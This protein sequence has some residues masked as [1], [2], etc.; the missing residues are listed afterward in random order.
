MPELKWSPEQLIR[1]LAFVNG[2]GGVGKTSLVANLAGLYAGGGYKVL[3]VDLDPQGNVGNDLGYIGAGRSDDGKALVSA[4]STGHAIIPL[5]N[6]RPNLDVAC[7]GEQ[8]DELSDALEAGHGGGVTALAAALAQVAES[9]DLVLIDC[10]PGNKPLQ[11]LGLAAARWLVIPTKS[12]DGSR[13]GLAKVARLFTEI[14]E[15]V[16]PWIELL[17]VVLFGVGSTAT[18]VQN[19]VRADL[20]QDLDNPGIVF[21]ST[22][23]HAEAAAYDA[24]KRGQLMHEL[25]RDVATAPKWHER[26]KTGRKAETLAASAGTVAGDYQRLAEE[27]IDRIVAAET[28]DLNDRVDVLEGQEVQA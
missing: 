8:L 4:I 11:R 26:F 6:V 19:S 21:I 14:R 7:G 13:L 20:G 15:E 1:C 17:G 16:N 2:K 24:R 18:R 10:P 5:T 12:D 28:V 27:L 3:I 25:E 23:R 22:I 9:Y